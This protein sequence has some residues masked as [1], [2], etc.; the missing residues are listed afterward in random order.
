VHQAGVVDHAATEATYRAA[1]VKATVQSFFDDP[2]AIMADADLAICRAGG[3][4]L[5]ELAATRLPSI[6]VPLDGAMD[7]HQRVNAR[8]FAAAGAATVVDDTTESVI[9]A[10]H[11]A[12]EIAQLMA[13]PARR[14]AMQTSLVHLA[15]PDAASHVGEIVQYLASGNKIAAGGN[16]PAFPASP[17]SIDASAA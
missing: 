16:S 11:L 12:I 8:S 9:L 3:S 6:L 5:A 17:G 10:K 14:V 15:R 13:N 7:D 4:T 2:A 1:G